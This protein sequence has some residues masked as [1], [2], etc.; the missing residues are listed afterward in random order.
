[1]R[2]DL[3]STLYFYLSLFTSPVASSRQYSHPMRRITKTTAPPG[4]TNDVDGTL[5]P[6]KVVADSAMN[7]AVAAL[8]PAAIPCMSI[9]SRKTYLKTL[10]VLPQLT[11]VT[12]SSTKSVCSR[13]SCE[14]L[15]TIAVA[16]ASLVLP[17]ND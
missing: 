9:L 10:V 8:I 11:R 3:T 17:G 7:A 12:Y 5:A 2:L 6:S 14:V 15:G 13:L 4:D 1:M 16:R